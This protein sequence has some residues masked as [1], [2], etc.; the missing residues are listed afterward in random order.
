MSRLPLP[1]AS[2][3]VALR[4][5]KTAV[6]C[7]M[8]QTSLKSSNTPRASTSTR[9]TKHS[10]TRTCGY[11]AAGRPSGCTVKL[12]RELLRMR[13][14]RLSVFAIVL[15][16]C[17]NG[18]GGDAATP[19]VPEQTQAISAIPSQPETL[20]PTPNATS[21]TATPVKQT[22]TVIKSA[23]RPVRDDAF[24]RHRPGDLPLRQGA[25]QQARV[26]RRLR[27]GMATGTHRRLA[28]AAGGTKQDL[29]GTIKRT[30]QVTYRGHPQ[31]FYAHEG[32][33]EV[34]CH[35]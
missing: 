27:R 13:L 33:N 4:R 34:K 25:D 1:R 22:G 6:E 9:S 28:S 10:T 35:N 2:T 3:D 11:T 23:K 21:P 26:L 5:R 30:T 17:G 24:R 31:Y 12:G 18:A 29:L 7:G 15:A 20:L 16:G 8:R 32:K 19:G 14:A